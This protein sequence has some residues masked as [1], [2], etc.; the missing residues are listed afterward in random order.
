MAKQRDARTN[1]RM[2]RC[3][4]GGTQVFAPAPEARHVMRRSEWNIVDKFGRIIV[5]FL[6]GAALLVPMILM[7]IPFK[8]KPKARVVTVSI[9]VMVFGVVLAI[10]TKASY[11]EVIA[12]T[13]AYTA[14][15]AVYIGSASP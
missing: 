11:Q 4:L 8:N 6:G 10:S 7:S 15:L 9:A 13:A 2:L 1:I 5:A 12:A 14:V 3:D